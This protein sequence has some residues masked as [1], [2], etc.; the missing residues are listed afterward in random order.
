MHSTKR[1]S[2][3]LSLLPLLGHQT[4]G[5]PVHMCRGCF[6]H[7]RISKE[8]LQLKML[9]LLD[10]SHVSAALDGDAHHLYCGPSGSNTF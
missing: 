10:R 5:L 2:E 8:H 7:L 3:R 6:I 1:R 4:L 9:M